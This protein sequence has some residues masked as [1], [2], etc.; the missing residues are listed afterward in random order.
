MKPSEEMR[1]ACEEIWEE[2]GIASVQKRAKWAWY[3]GRLV[4]FVG[5]RYLSIYDTESKT[6][7]PSV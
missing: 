4:P 1:R 7:E 3:R 6:D 2:K 5:K